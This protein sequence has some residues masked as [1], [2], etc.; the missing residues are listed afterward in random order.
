MLYD[1]I[2]VVDLGQWYKYDVSGMNS[3]IQPF[4]PEYLIECRR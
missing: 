2:Y 4:R 1:S 3:Y